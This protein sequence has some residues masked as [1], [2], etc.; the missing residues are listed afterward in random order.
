[1]I[2]QNDDDLQKVLS[3]I[4]AEKYLATMLNT[5]DY[6]VIDIYLFKAIRECSF[7]DCHKVIAIYKYH[8]Q[9]ISYATEHPELEF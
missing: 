7:S 5:T 2:I 6:Y 9:T 4:D 8:L 3:K 1:M